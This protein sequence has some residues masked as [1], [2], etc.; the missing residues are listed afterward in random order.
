MDPGTALSVASLA[1][2]VVK[3]LYEYFRAWKDC[4]KDDAELRAHLLWLQAAFQ[5]TE[6]A[7]KRTG[8]AAEDRSQV[9]SALI[10]CREAVNELKE[11][12]DKIKAKDAKPQAA[13]QKLKAQGRKAVYPFRK[14]TI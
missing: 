11:T 7:L 5:A 14:S 9:E 6:N 3:D 8:L 4:D 1:Y 2:D 13:L 12:L 10:R